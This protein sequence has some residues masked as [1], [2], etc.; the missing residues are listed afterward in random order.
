MLTS[1]TKEICFT[2]C[3][4]KSSLMTTFYKHESPRHL[5]GDGAF[6]D[7]TIDM[8]VDSEPIPMHTFDT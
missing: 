7:Y 6:R 8:M 4:G 3:I 2:A 5:G 1:I